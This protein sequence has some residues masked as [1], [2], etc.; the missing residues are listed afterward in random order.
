MTRQDEAE[1]SDY[2][3]AT[4]EGKD[5]AEVHNPRGQTEDL[6]EQLKALPTTEAKRCYRSRCRRILQRP[7]TV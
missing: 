1:L 4:E 5:K 2:T 3:E 7:S 6:G